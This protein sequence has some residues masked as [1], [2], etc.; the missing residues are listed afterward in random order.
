[1]MSV[2]EVHESAIGTSQKSESRRI[3]DLSDRAPTTKSLVRPERRRL[4]RHHQFRSRRV[5][6]EVTVF[7]DWSSVILR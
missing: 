3:T 2:A 6:T 5:K 1:L 7:T 4:L